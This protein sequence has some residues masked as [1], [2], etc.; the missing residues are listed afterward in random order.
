MQ[1]IIF[2]FKIWIDV[3]K[4]EESDAILKYVF[5]WDTTRYTLRHT[6]AASS[7]AQNV[8]KYALSGGSFFEATGVIKK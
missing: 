2:K 5:R 3:V 4:K 8:R 6:A 7:F 1:N